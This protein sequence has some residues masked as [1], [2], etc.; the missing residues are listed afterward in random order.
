VRIY[1]GGFPVGF[2]IGRTY[3]RHQFLLKDG[4]SILEE[5]QMRRFCVA[6]AEAG[7]MPTACHPKM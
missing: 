1:G 2:R 5:R 7:V 3:F 6:L 4:Q